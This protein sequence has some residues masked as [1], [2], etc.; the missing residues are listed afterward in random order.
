MGLNIIPMRT[1][2]STLL[3]FLFFTQG[4][5]PLQVE[6]T[7]SPATFLQTKQSPTHAYRIEYLDLDALNL[8]LKQDGEAAVIDKLQREFLREW[9]YLD[10]TRFAPQYLNDLSNAMERIQPGSARALIIELT[11]TGR[12]EL[13]NSYRTQWLESHGMKTDNSSNTVYVI[14]DRSDAKYEWVFIIHG[15]EI[16]AQRHVFPG[17]SEQTVF[18][19]QVATPTTLKVLKEII[20]AK[21]DI[22]PPFVPESPW[23]SR[24][25][26]QLD[27]DTLANSAYFSNTNAQVAHQAREMQL[28]VLKFGKPLDGLPLWIRGSAKIMERLGHFN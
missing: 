11:S 25:A 5:R 20:S 9:P 4:C 26:I 28:T 14:H 21:G 7:D 23:R 15:Q 8:A 2:I 3:L 22:K 13:Q 10:H 1:L 12:Y 19:L 6:E 17:Y 18:H 27:Q 16:I 24:A